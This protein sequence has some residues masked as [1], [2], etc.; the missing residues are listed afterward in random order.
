[1]GLVDSPALTS[2]DRSR[3]ARERIHERHVELAVEAAHPMSWYQLV[4]SNG[5]V[6]GIDRFGASAPFQKLYEEYGITA[7]RVTAAARGLLA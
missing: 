5:A 1:M 2:V 6:V 7:A 3:D 4:G